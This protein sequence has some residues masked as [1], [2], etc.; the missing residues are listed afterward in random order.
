MAKL[1]PLTSVPRDWQLKMLGQKFTFFREVNFVYASGSRMMCTFYLPKPLEVTITGFTFKREGKSESH[2]D[3]DS[4]EYVNWKEFT[5]TK[6]HA[7]VLG[8]ELPWLKERM[9]L[10]IDIINSWF[11]VK[12]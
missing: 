1:K 6:N 11:G 2:S 3:F 5:A 10:Q 7:I 9:F 8:R 12:S 4:G